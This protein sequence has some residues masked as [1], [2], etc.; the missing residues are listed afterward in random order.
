MLDAGTLAPDAYSAD[1]GIYADARANVKKLSGARRLEL[2][3]VIRD[4][5]DMA[6]RGQFTPPACRR[7]F[8]R[9]SATPSTGPPAR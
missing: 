1:T 6:A 4:L 5:E 8:S 2:S 9:C 7:C 3:G